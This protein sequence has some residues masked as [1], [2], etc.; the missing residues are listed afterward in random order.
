MTE[1][2]QAQTMLILFH[3]TVKLVSFHLTE[4]ALDY[5]DFFF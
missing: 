4:L 5:S 1:L 2:D 3:L